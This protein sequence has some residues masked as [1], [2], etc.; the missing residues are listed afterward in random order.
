MDKYAVNKLVDWG[1]RLSVINENR[2][3]FPEDFYFKNHFKWLAG[4]A[5]IV[6]EY[7]DAWDCIDVSCVFS[8]K[9][10]KRE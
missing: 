6:Q 3:G 7:G 10:A 5:T 1:Y 4:I 8:I 2:D 9:P